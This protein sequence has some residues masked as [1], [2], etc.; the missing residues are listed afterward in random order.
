VGLQHV[1]WLSHRTKC[2]IHRLRCFP[3][4]VH[5][6]KELLENSLPFTAKF[7]VAAV[8]HVCTV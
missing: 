6:L 5:L 8:V 3:G 4:H 7:G 2:Y 1:D